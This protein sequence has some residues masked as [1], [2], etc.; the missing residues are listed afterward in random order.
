MS[1]EDRKKEDHENDDLENRE[2][3]TA[4][5]RLENDLPKKGSH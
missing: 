4:G 3:G 5:Q 2:I 1:L